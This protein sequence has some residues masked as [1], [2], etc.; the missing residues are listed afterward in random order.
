[1]STDHANSA[2]HPSVV[3]KLHELWGWRPLNDRQRLRVAVRLQVKVPGR[4]LSLRPTN[5]TPALSVTQKRCCSF[6]MQL[7]APLYKYYVLSTSGFCRKWPKNA[8][9][10][11][12]ARDAPCIRRG[13]AKVRMERD[14]TSVSR[15]SCRHCHLP[16]KRDREAPATTTN[17]RPMNNTST[18]LNEPALLF[19]VNLKQKTTSLKQS[20][21]ATRPTPVVV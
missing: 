2:F 5:C 15:P 16:A 9:I 17:Q 4:W 1:V 14:H 19:C 11:A 8:Q 21:T 18:Q 20:V 12:S 13:C 10:C 6:G 7:L 3:G